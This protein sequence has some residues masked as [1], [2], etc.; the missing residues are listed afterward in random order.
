MGYNGMGRD[1]G[2][3]RWDGWV[4]PPHPPPPGAALRPAA[5]HAQPLYGDPEPR[6][7]AAVAVTVGGGDGHGAALR[8]CAPPRRAERVGTRRDSATLR[9]GG[10]IDGGGDG[11]G[12]DPL[13]AGGD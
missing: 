4:C 1:G 8:L 13:T 9:R 12:A 7:P 6:G 2:G 11:L 3:I 5:P 10:P